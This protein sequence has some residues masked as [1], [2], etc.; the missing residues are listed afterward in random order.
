MRSS[1]RKAYRH[2]DY[3]TGDSPLRI[4][5]KGISHPISFAKILPVLIPEDVAIIGNLQS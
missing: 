2:F 3:K 1:W 4:V 5:P